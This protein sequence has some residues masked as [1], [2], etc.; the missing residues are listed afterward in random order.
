MLDSYAI[1]KIRIKGNFALIFLSNEEKIILPRTATLLAGLKKGASI[2]ISELKELKIRAESI[3]A[4]DYALR[5]LSRRPYSEG[6]LKRKM[7]EKGFSAKIIF[8]II[9]KLG[10]E[11]GLDDRAYASQI[12][13]SLLRR[14]PAGRRFLTAYLQAREIPIL[15]ATEIVDQYLQNEDEIEMAE[16]LLRAR[17]GYLSKFGLDA[18]RIKAYNYLSRRSIGYRAARKAF[19][20]LL[21]EK[22]GN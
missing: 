3:R 17:W 10:R 5:L 19:D 13:E 20:K 9:K 6:M 4:E 16:K 8:D 12:V 15:L 18:A 11:G 2:S 14:R 21:R 22:N 7:R 1:E